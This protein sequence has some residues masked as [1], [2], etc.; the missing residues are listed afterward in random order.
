MRLAAKCKAITQNPENVKINDENVETVN[1][2]IFLGSNVPNTSADVKRR[3]FLANVAFGKLQ[4]NIWSRGD[5]SIALKVRLY[6]VLIL[7]IAIYGSETW[8]LTKHDAQKLSVFENNCIRTILGIRLQDRVSLKKLWKK[9][10]LK[11][12]AMYSLIGHR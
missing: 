10:K 11:A 6:K 2:F 12:G 3:I 5:I 1:N 8:S 9:A 4:K 7:L